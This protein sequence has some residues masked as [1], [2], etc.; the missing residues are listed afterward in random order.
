MSQILNLLKPLKKLKLPKIL[1]TLKKPILLKAPKSQKTKIIFST[2]FLKKTITRSRS[3]IPLRSLFLS[4]PLKGF[5]SLLQAPRLTLLLKLLLSLLLSLTLIP[6]PKKPKRI[7][8]SKFRPKKKKLKLKKSSSVS[9]LL[10][11]LPVSRSLFTFSFSQTLVPALFL[12]FST[13]SVVP[14]LNF[15]NSLLVIP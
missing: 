11:L 15:S 12:K 3:K 9:L 1:K 2:R 6:L 8:T 10:L 5:L 14:I 4:Q 13:K 7:P